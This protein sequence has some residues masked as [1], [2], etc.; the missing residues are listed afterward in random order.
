MK[1]N[2]KY[3][4]NRFGSSDNEFYSFRFL[5]FSYEGR[6][7]E[8]SKT[9]KFSSKPNSAHISGFKNKP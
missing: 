8:G 4:S 7:C 2:N 6:L 9:L 5:F 3:S 1:K